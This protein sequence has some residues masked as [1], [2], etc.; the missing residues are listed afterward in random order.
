MNTK[1][2]SLGRIPENV[3][4]Q[5]QEAGTGEAARILY[6]FTAG[7]KQTRKLKPRF[8]KAKKNV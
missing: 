3:W 1:S 8:K 2:P 7:R 5:A 6:P 4:K